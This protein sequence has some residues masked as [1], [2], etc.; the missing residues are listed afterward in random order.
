MGNRSI[1]TEG[2]G[3]GDADGRAVSLGVLG[4]LGVF[5]PAAAGECWDRRFRALCAGLP[6]SMA[7]GDTTVEQSSTNH[8]RLFVR[9]IQAVETEDGGLGG[10][11]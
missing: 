7:A 5:F 1:R 2:S 8:G 9:D 3:Y 6:S 10:F 4:V 11:G